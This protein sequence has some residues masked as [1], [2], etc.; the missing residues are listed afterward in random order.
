MKILKNFKVIVALILAL[1]AIGVLIGYCSRAPSS[2]LTRAE[3]LQAIE[4]KEIT[5]AAITPMLYQGFY[6]VEGNYLRSPGAK[7]RAFTITTHLDEK[8]LKELLVQTNTKVDL[9]GQGGKS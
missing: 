5:H 3:L 4:H 6:T 8:Q 1:G 9:P 2:E 7:P